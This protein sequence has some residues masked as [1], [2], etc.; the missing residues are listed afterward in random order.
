MGRRSSKVI[1]GKQ[2]SG[3]HFVFF[4][5]KLFTIPMGIGPL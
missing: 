2:R 3:Y 4:S 1:T 5:L